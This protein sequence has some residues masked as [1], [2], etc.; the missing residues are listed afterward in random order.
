MKQTPSTPDY[1]SATALDLF[2]LF[3]LWFPSPQHSSV[4]LTSDPF[5]LASSL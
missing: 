5:D 3:L 1:L 4:S 2:S